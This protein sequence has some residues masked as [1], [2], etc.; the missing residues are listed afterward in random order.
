MY[1]PALSFCS[2]WAPNL[3][4]GYTNF[5]PPTVTNLPPASDRKGPFSR[6]FL[7]CSKA[8]SREIL[9][10][11]SVMFPYL[12]LNLHF[13]PLNSCPGLN[14]GSGQARVGYTPGSPIDPTIRNPPL[15]CL[16]MPASPFSTHPK[17]VLGVGDSPS[18]VPYVGPPSRK[19][20]IPSALDCIW[21]PSVSTPLS[22]FPR[23]IS[24]S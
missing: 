7:T 1:S 23:R 20:S 13:A 19:S 9:S 5:G 14:P 10:L 12:A 4:A 21:R 6:P 18:P 15:N 8:S 3:T 24:R 17:S 16:T 22:G 2:C 11:R